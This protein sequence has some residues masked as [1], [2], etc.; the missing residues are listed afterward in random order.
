MYWNKSTCR[1]HGLGR[2]AGIAVV[3]DLFTNNVVDRDLLADNIVGRD[4]LTM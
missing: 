2:S 4:L 1:C 3:G